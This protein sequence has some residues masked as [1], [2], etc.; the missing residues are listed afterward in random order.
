M[1]ALVILCSAVK[2]TIY[3][4]CRLYAWVQVCLECRATLS[5]SNSCFRLSSTTG[6]S[7]HGAVLPRYRLQL[8]SFT[9]Y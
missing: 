7:K 2:K 5:F 3:L 8:S 1:A 4:C 6:S 9:V